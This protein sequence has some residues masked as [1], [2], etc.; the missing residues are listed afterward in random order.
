MAVR[1]SALRTTEGKY[2]RV[3]FCEQNERNWQD[4]FHNSLEVSIPFCGKTK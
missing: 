4:A 3:L 2:T 1:L